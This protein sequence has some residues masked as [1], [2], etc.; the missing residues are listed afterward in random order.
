MKPR[1]IAVVVMFNINGQL[2]RRFG[3]SNFDYIK[4]N[5]MTHVT[6][7]W[8]IAPFLSKQS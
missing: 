5:R 2:Q 7:L 8:Y 3:D 1:H 6:F 4:H